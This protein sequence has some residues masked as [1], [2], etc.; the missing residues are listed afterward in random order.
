MKKILLT[1]FLF[2]SLSCLSQEFKKT[3]SKIYG[4]EEI[5]N[6]FSKIYKKY[7]AKYFY[8][9]T[10]KKRL[11]ERDSI[12]NI[13]AAGRSKYSVQVFKESSKNHTFGYLIDNVPEG[14]RAHL[15]FYDNPSVFK[16]PIGCVFQD[17]ENL[18]ILRENN[19]DWSSE[20][21]VEDSYSL[22]SENSSLDNGY[23][24]QRY[25]NYLRKNDNPSEDTFLN[26]YLTSSAHKNAI[27][28]YGNWKFGCNSKF[29]VAK[30]YNKA[31]GMWRYE[32][33]ACHTIII[34]KNFTD[35]NVY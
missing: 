21:F 35:S 2:L 23:V 30:Q 20:L 17:K 32:V 24:L 29:I 28:K 19:M 9:V 10:G 31:K 33:F 16:E 14:S 1:A 7:S 25:A 6:H 11:I 3:Y 34:L 18:P 12:L 8:N 26:S 5:D 4:W 22:E 27:H 13:V 15:R